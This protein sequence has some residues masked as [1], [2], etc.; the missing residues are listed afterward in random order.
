MILDTDDICQE[1][2]FVFGSD[3]ANGNASDRRFNGNTGV[4]KRHGGTTSGSHG[5]GTIGTHDFGNDADG[6]GEFFFRRDD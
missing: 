6:I 1:K 4:H 5:C 2:I 3:Q